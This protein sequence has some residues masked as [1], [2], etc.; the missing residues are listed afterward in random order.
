MAAAVTQ[1]VEGR[2][3][4]RPDAGPPYVAMW[5]DDAYSKDLTGRFL[6]ALERP[7]G[8]GSAPPPLPVSDPIDYSVGGF[9]Q[10]N[11]WE[12]RV[13][14]FLMEE[15][16]TRFPNQRRPLLVLAAPGSQQA[17][18]F[19]RGLER[20]A[21]A[22]ARR[23]VVVTGDTLSFNTI[24]RDRN[25]LWPIQDLPFDLVFF[26]HR[27][28][29]EGSAGFVEDTPGVVHE[30][31]QATGLT[32]RGTGTED[33]LLYMDIVEAL[34]QAANQGD[35]MPASG[36][37]LGERLRRARWREGRVSFGDEGPPLFDGDGNRGGGTGEH[38]VWL[39]PVV[40]DGR[41]PEGQQVQAKSVIKVY[42]W[43]GAA[44]VGTWQEVRQL[45]AEYEGAGG[46]R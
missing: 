6:N 13:V 4:L 38:I 7:V 39:R 3:E 15:K 32:P 16:I 33:L 35:A 12:A 28:P 14:R 34:A 46:D 22:E 1:F 31:A 40:V 45:D 29:V 21:P 26:C 20:R 10:P 9:D 19:L 43:Q 41:R 30:D 23:F 27:N 44:E 17:R 25:D 11:R 42:N 18:R 8:D 37:E 5:E 24:Y 36:D 2:D